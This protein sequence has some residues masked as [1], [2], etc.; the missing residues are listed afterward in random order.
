MRASGRNRTD[1]YHL[2]EGD[3]FPFRHGGSSCIASSP[4]RVKNIRFKPKLMAQNPSPSL[5]LIAAQMNDGFHIQIGCQGE[6]RGEFRLD[7]PA[8]VGGFAVIGEYADGASRR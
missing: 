6:G 7:L 2:F 1:S 3:A 5:P 8:L 4:T